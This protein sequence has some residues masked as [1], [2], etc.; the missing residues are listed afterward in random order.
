MFSC[1]LCFEQLL[2]ERSLRRHMLYQHHSVY[3]R[4]RSPVQLSPDELRVRLEAE[5]RRQMNSRQRRRRQEAERAGAVTQSDEGTSAGSLFHLRGELF[6]TVE[7]VCLGYRPAGSE[8]VSSHESFN[9]QGDWDRPLSDVGSGQDPGDLVP[10]VLTADLELFDPGS[11]QPP[12]PPTPPPATRP[13][14]PPPVDAAIQVGP[15]VRMVMTQVGAEC[16]SCAPQ[17]PPGGYSLRDL[18]ESLDR[19]PDISAQHIV[20]RLGRQAVPEMSL[21]DVA[22]LSELFSAMVAAQSTLVGRVRSLFDAGGV[23][24]D[25]PSASDRIQAVRAYVSGLESRPIWRGELD[26]RWDIRE[27]QGPQDVVA[28]PSDC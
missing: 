13:P 10:D 28:M 23:P 4:H 9:W 3:R 21:A 20:Q 14:L 1:D 19:W 15:S 2:N 22:R 16:G 11:F 8:S 27:F 7:P 12:L 25:P 5:G 24:G 6:A 17:P 18:A 26:Q